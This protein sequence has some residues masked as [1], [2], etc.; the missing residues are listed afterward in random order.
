MYE[1]IIGG[2]MQDPLFDHEG[3]C[4]ICD[5]HFHEHSPDDKERCRAA[6]DMPEL[7]D[8]LLGYGRESSFTD[9][10]AAVR[11]LSAQMWRG[12]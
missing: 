3:N 9:D 6:F 5:G 11:D 2:M 4:A 1:T 10:D 7:E 8:R 12:Q